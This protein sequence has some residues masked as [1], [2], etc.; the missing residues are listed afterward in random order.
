MDVLASRTRGLRSLDIERAVEAFESMGELPPIPEH[1]T[2]TCDPYTGNWCE[3][4]LD[5]RKVAGKLCDSGFTVRV[6]AGYYG[7]HGCGSRLK[8][9]ARL[10]ANATIRTLGAWGLTLAPFYCVHAVRGVVADTS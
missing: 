1:P 6:L 9:L 7:S 4:L 10:G 3:R 8:R 5:P 2:N